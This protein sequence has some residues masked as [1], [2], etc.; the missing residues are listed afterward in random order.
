[1]PHFS[2]MDFAETGRSAEL[3]MTA[4]RARA[5]PRIDLLPPEPRKPGR[6]AAR[7]VA[8]PEVV[9][10]HFVVIG[11]RNA[12]SN[13]NRRPE[14]VTAGA[15]PRLDATLRLLAAAG[16]LGERGLQRL[17]SRAFAGLVTA[18]CLFAFAYAGGLGALKAALPAAQP[19]SPLTVS[20]LSVRLEDRN[21]MRVLAIR[22]RLANVSG[23][24]QAT[25]PLDVTIGTVTRRVAVAAR[26]LAPGEGDRFALRIPHAGGK[27]PK[28]A[29]S[30]AD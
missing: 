14:T 21:G 30:V 24:V 13:D 19:A 25:S 8:R 29:V 17:P 3:A 1:M 23:V 18:L 28:V 15:A 20:D 27:L 11:A 12:T 10:A 9:D 5:E 6:N 2:R 7:T 22:G 16:R 26:V 4:S